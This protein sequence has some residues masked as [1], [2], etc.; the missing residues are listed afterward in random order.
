MTMKKMLGAFGA[1]VAAAAFAAA[2]AVAQQ[3]HGH[4]HGQ[5]HAEGQAHRCMMHNGAQMLLEHHRQE[6]GLSADQVTRLEA[7]AAE[8][9]A[10]HDQHRAHGQMQDA[11]A[12]QRRA[13]HQ[14][15]MAQ[16]RQY[17]E[18]V[19]A[20]LTAE[21]RSR[22]EAMM[23]QHHAGKGH[24]EGHAQH[25]QGGHEGGDC[26][27]DC[28]DCEESCKDCGARCKEYCGEGE[29]GQHAGA[30]AHG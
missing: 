14:Q 12:E 15:M 20:V 26:C 18:R 16:M 10:H 13:M 6:L 24:G 3:G 11:S 25:G 8:M 27:A 9:K 28:E 22:I 17:H 30:H 2:P 19:H 5:G 23:Q 7:I 21:Q 1:A 29:H 4:G